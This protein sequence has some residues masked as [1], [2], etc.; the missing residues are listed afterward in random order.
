MNAMQNKFAAEHTEE[1]QEVDVEK[2]QQQ[3]EPMDTSESAT[4]KPVAVGKE[5]T[6]AT[7]P[8]AR[9]ICIM[10]QEEQSLMSNFKDPMVI[11]C[12]VKNTTV[13]SQ[14]RN[15]SSPGSATCN[16]EHLDSHLDLGPGV[17]SCGHA[18]H[19]KCYQKFFDSLIVKERDRARQNG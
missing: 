2:Q 13:L 4:A 5:R 15:K 7:I 9:Y 10:C 16:E 14:I 19:S 1:L 6:P 17:R 8:E 11:A 3:E 18:M 12:H